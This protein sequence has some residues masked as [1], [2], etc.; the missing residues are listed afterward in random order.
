MTTLFHHSWTYSLIRSTCKACKASGKTI[1]HQTRSH[2]RPPGK[3]RTAT[4]RRT[5]DGNWRRS[6]REPPPRPLSR[7]A[8]SRHPRRHIRLRRALVQQNTAITKPL[9]A[10]T[11]ERG[12]RTNRDSATT[13]EKIETEPAW[14]QQPTRQSCKQIKQPR[15]GRPTSEGPNT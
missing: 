15:R 7:R 1:H 11:R 12:S 10:R 6:T 14:T 5:T 13:T 3:A 2:L 9:K 8:P 4:A